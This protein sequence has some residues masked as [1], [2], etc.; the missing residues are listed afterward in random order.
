[1]PPSEQQEA[2]KLRELLQVAERAA[3]TARAQADQAAQQGG[4][5][6]TLRA[7]YERSGA[8]AALL[9]A[10]REALNEARAEGPG[11]RI[12]RPA[13]CARQID[14]LPRAARTLRRGARG[15]SRR[16]SRE[17]RVTHA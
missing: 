10:R 17:G 12:S 16:R 14:E 6:N 8:A 1:M 4:N 3:G 11:Q 9:E 7:I 2:S 5:P 13:I 15:R